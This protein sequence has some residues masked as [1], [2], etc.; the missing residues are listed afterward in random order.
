MS[1]MSKVE[2]AEG[3]LAAA[4]RQM[5]EQVSITPP[6]KLTEED[7][8]RLSTARSI[9][10]LIRAIAYPPDPISPEPELWDD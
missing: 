5:V 6:H 4:R 9:A 2:K 3:A 1:L 7:A 10:V 8:D